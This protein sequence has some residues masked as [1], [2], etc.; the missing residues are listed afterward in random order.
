MHPSSSIHPP[1]RPVLSRG[2]FLARL[3]DER[4]RSDRSL[5]SFAVLVYAPGERGEQTVEELGATL[6]DRVRVG[7]AVGLLS[8]HEVAVLLMRVGKEEASRLAVEL[9]AGLSGPKAPLNC[10]VHPHPPV[11]WQEG[12]PQAREVSEGA[13]VDR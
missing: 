11:A 10:V 9:V 3:R 1:E 7:D 6:V 2:E 12:R 8:G 4:A 13:G 5:T